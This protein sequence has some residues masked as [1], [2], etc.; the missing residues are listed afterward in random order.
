MNLLVDSFVESVFVGVDEVINRHSYNTTKGPLPGQ[1]RS[2]NNLLVA[3]FVESIFVGVDGVINRRASDRNDSGLG[4]IFRMK[5]PD[6]GLGTDA[7]Q[8][9]RFA[10]QRRHHASGRSRVGG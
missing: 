7:F 4:R 8:R 6:C 10:Q 9:N 1:V 2:Q 5:D 3:S